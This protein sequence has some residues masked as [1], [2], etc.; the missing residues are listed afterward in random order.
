MKNFMRIMILASIIPSISMAEY[1]MRYTLDGSAISIKNPSVVTPPVITPKWIPAES[2]TTEWS[3][4]GP[5]TA[6]SNWAP[7]ADTMIFD[8]YFTQTATDCQQPQ[9]RTVQ[10]REQNDVTLEYRNV[11]SPTIENKNI[12]VTDTKQEIGTKVVGEC[13]YSS[14]F[15]NDTF[16]IDRNYSD[17]ASIAWKGV[18][19]Y[20]TS[21]TGKTIT[22]GG[23][24]YTR[25]DP[26]MRTTEFSG[27]RFDYYYTI[28]K[29]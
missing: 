7:S 12:T 25:I 19:I 8:E 3:N 4:N 1:S 20:E 2:V 24:K 29:H 15:G 23:Y 6:C 17:V 5:I 22:V 16:W 14:G 9:S 27:G 13:G 10:E 11:G 21:A 26:I 18:M 28:C